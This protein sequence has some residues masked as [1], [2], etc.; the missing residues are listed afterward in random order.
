MGNDQLFKA[1]EQRVKSV[2]QRLPKIV[3]N[4][5]VNFSLDA[6]RKQGWTG[7]SF[8]P[9]PKRKVNTKWGTPPRNNGRNIL[10]LDGRLR[11]GTRVVSADW[12]SIKIGNSVPYA[13][14][15]NNGLRIGLIQTVR[16]HRRKVASRNGNGVIAGNLNKKGTAQKIKYGQTSSG[17]AFVK[18]HKR[19]INQRIPQRQFMGSS[20]YLTRNIH[21]LI[22]SQINKAI[23][24]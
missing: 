6:F 1:L 21:R 13:S 20:P 19:R 23:N 18:S 5:A 12:N 2:M 24:S 8:Q 10:T 3:G 4:E 9:W 11:R 17:V 7:A 22:A 15:H 14:A 16:T